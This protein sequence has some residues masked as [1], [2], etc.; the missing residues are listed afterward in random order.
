MKKLVSLLLAVSICLSMVFMLTGCFGGKNAWQS[1]LGAKGWNVSKANAPIVK[2]NGT[3]G[4]VSDGY[5]FNGA[6]S[7][8]GRGNGEFIEASA[9]HKE[10]HI[11]ATDG[12]TDEQYDD[13]LLIDYMMTYSSKKNTLYVEVVNY[14]Y[15]TTSSG[16]EA[17]GSP[18]WLDGY[19]YVSQAGGECFINMTF[20]MAGYFANGELTEEDI[21][22]EGEFDTEG[23]RNKMGITAGTPYT[24]RNTNW[25]TQAF[26]SILRSVN[27]FA[28][29][30]DA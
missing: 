28:D 17:D 11:S 8:Q 1:Y 16:T 13:Y 21:T 30:I 7:I 5:S 27:D 26:A 23:I 12:V 10:S 2:N 29:L 4:A 20:D 19:Y 14:Y 6:L 22:K 25:D 18:K 3:V 9:I 24:E 15:H